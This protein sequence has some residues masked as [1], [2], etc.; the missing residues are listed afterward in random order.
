MRSTL[1]IHVTYMQCIKCI[2]PPQ[3]T[4]AVY[5]AAAFLPL[6]CSAAGAGGCRNA[7]AAAVITLTAMLFSITCFTMNARGRALRQGFKGI[8]EWL[9]SIVTRYFTTPP[10]TQSAAGWPGNGP[11]SAC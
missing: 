7:L 9:R 2:K 4:I 11:Q 10:P 1:G 8:R 3:Q 5:A 6:G